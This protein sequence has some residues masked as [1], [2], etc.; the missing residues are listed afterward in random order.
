MQWVLDN[1]KP[2]DDYYSYYTQDFDVTTSSGDISVNG[3]AIESQVMTFSAGGTVTAP[4]VPVNNLGCDAADFPAG[5]SGQ[6]ALIQRGT[7]AFGVKATNAK[8]AGAVGA[9][10]YNNVPGVVAGTLGGEGD[11]PATIGITQADGQAFVAAIAAGTEQIA[12]VNVIHDV[13]TTTN[14]IAETKAGNH[15]NVVHLGGH[16]DSVIAG[17]GINDNGSGSAGLLEVA[18]QLTNFKVNNAVRFSWWA[19]EEEG[20]LGAAH[21]VEQSTPEELAQIRLYLNFDMIGSPNYFYGVYDGDGSEFGTTGPLGS[22][23]AEKLFED[24]FKS[25][26]IQSFPTDFSGRS[27]YGPFLENGVASGGLFTGAEELKTPEQAAA[28]GGEAGVAF[29]VCYHAACDDIANIAWEAQTANTKAIAHAVGT[30]AVSTAQLDAVAP[31]TKRE[32]KVE[33]R[34]WASYNPKFRGG[35]ALF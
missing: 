31:V 26:G 22:A 28:N 21:F 16:S 32:A 6:I 11:Y 17:P 4:L 24:Y 1:L 20:L 9:V 10:I 13:T 8:A 18:K 29:D 15:S 19:A 14:V 34:A 35:H 3:A 25:V 27:D 33:K 12:T 2:F 30:L 23:Q 7:C 5:V